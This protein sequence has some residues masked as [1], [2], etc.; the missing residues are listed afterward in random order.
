MKASLE[1]IT[2]L[3]KQISGSNAKLRNAQN[4]MEQLETQF[5][6]QLG[7]AHKINMGLEEQILKQSPSP[8]TVTENSKRDA[9]IQT[10]P[11]SYQSGAYNRQ[12]NE[13]LRN[14]NSELHAALKIANAEIEKLTKELETRP[15]CPSL[16][17]QPTIWGDRRPAPPIAVSQ[18]TPKY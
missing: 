12:H 11:P 13:V 7:L 4:E 9:E 18:Y 15:K 14:V 16:A 10:D 5:A 17:V 6:E 8:F 1:K 2:A 3:E